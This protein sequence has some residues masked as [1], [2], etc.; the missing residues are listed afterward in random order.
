MAGRGRRANKGEMKSF[1][2]S[3]P[4]KL[5][6]YLGYLAAHNGIGGSESEVA[7][8]FLRAKLI[9]LAQAKFHELE[10]PALKPDE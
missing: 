4:L 6:E 8:Y 10:L 7:S 5:Y 3:I 1:S 2:V 9:E